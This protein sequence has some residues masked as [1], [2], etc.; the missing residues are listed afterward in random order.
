M[1]E[2]LCGSLPG[3][4]VHAAACVLGDGRGVLIPANTHSGK[5]TLVASMLARWGARFI[6]DDRIWL[7]DG[8]ASGFG[9]PIAVRAGSPFWAHAQALWPN[10]DSER[11]LLRPVDLG[12]PAWVREGTIDRLVFPRFEQGAR[13]FM[14]LGAPEAFCRMVGSLFRKCSPTELLALATL[15]TRCPAVSITYGDVDTSL[16]L[17]GQFLQS[18][19]AVPAEAEP[20]EAVP[21]LLDP[22]ELQEGEF[23]S[24]IEG[25]R[26]G[27][28]VVVWNGA[29]GQL[30]SL[31]SWS[32]GPLAD[33]AAH[34]QLRELGFLVSRGVANVGSPN[35][36]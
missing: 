35:R 12:A 11:L 14:R 9:A 3:I 17:L 8:V 27:A 4:P 1:G 32:G 22:L 31:G 25:I 36:V 13:G 2:T 6:A 30:V 21:E 33:G 19:E 24:N 34:D 10:D 20:A 5:S 18:P 16:Q 23:A 26:F 28:H 15:A 29:M 7:N